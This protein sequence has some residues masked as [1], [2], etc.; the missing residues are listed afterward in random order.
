MRLYFDRCRLDTH[1][2]AKTSFEELSV[3]RSCFI[4]AVPSIA[5]GVGMSVVCVGDL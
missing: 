5:L 4:A 3:F 1:P 2:Y